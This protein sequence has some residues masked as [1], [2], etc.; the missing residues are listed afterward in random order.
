[1]YRS[2]GGKNFQD[3]VCDIIDGWELQF[4]EFVNFQRVNFDI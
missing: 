2:S 3:V 4:F 1:M